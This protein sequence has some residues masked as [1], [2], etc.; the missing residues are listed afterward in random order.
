MFSAPPAPSPWGMQLG[1]SKGA[2]GIAEV[3]MLEQLC[4]SSIIV[5]SP[6]KWSDRCVLRCSKIA[7]DK[8]HVFMY[9]LERNAFLTVIHLDLNTWQLE[10]MVVFTYLVA[11]QILLL[12]RLTSSPPAFDSFLIYLAVLCWIHSCSAEWCVSF[13]PMYYCL[14]PNAKRKCFLPFTKKYLVGWGRESEE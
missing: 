8:S 9:T 5:S 1:I 6:E 7:N 4:S 2:R 11:L 10:A 12:H 14:Q 3:F 13:V